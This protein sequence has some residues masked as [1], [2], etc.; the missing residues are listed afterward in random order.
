MIRGAQHV[1]SVQVE[2]PSRWTCQIF[3]CKTWFLLYYH[4]YNLI[5]FNYMIFKIFI[6][7]RKLG[8]IV[9]TIIFQILDN[10][11]IRIKKIFMFFICNVIP[12]VGT[13]ESLE[14]DE[15]S[16]PMNFGKNF[17]EIS[18]SRPSPSW[19]NFC[20]QYLTLRSVSSL[21]NPQNSEMK[22]CENIKLTCWKSS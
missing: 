22:I 16:F 17:F 11:R 9:T 12:L 1:Q 5:C 2:R 6:S 18:F 15:D 3:V 8:S 7:L 19:I 20:S 13:M 10:E 21:N 4:T 14:E